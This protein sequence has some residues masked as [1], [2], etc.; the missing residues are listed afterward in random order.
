MK[1]WEYIC[2]QVHK[3]LEIS[4][5]RKLAKDGFNEYGVYPD[6]IEKSEGAGFFIAREESNKVLVVCGDHSL[7]N[8]FEG[9]E[10]ILNGQ[11]TKVCQLSNSNCKVLRKIFKYTNPQN[12][13]GIDL[14]MGLGDRLGLASPGHLRL[15]RGKGVFPVIAQQSIRELNLTS[16]TY[17][18]VLAAA[19]W[20]VYQ[21]GYKDGFGA[22]GDHLKTADEVKMAL[23][24]GYTMITLD[25]SEHID[26][27]AADLSGDELDKRYMG[28]PAE[29]R[30][31]LEEKYLDKSFKLNKRHACKDCGCDDTLITFD[32][33]SFRKTVLIY[34]N[35]IKFTIKIYNEEIKNYG[36]EIDFEMSIDETLTST[37]PESHFFVASELL[38]GGVE[39]TSMAPR[40]CGEFQK[41][42]DY[43]GNIAQFEKEFD[44][45]VK[46]AEHFGYKVSVHSGSDKFS[47]FPIIGELTGGRYHLKT[48][49]TNWLEAL[50][51]IA[52]RNPGL[53][54][55]LYKFAIDNEQKA[56]KYY[57][58]DAKA[59]AM[60]D[61]DTLKDSEL[62][63]ALNNN[64]CRQI[65][66]I[67]YGLML[68]AA[69]EKGCPIYKD[70]IYNVLMEYED[71]YYAVLEKHIGRHLKEL[72][73]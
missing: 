37:T 15:V 13:K 69:D 72:G 56:R 33:E 14:T 5:V 6:S 51:V 16:R 26:N 64:D 47:V 9:S 67:T 68:Q 35:A 46:I 31:R 25:C 38:G 4:D 62:E 32:A 63:A 3:M 18:D 70:R 65:L 55:E 28:L 30:K 40:F 58:V 24:S 43:K 12:H 39:I 29:D 10:S 44:V 23:N 53:F 27:G 20:A 34:L 71:D 7:F 59:E 22:D 52:A 66:H 21:E 1:K 11:K 73:V 41:G 8:E 48:A 17:D 42:I 61:I 36:R 54:R 50:R 2:E 19:S 60:P 45:H 49:G 57:H